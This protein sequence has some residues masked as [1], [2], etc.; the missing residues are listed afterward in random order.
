MVVNESV[1]DL[2]VA[3]GLVRRFGTR[4]AVDGVDLVGRRGEIVGLL[5][6]NG[7]GKTTT[8]RMFA[9]ILPP[10]A[11]TVLLDGHDLATAPPAARTPLAYLPEQVAPYP[12][13]TVASYLRFFARVWRVRRS[14]VAGAVSSA[15]AALDL[16][17][18]AKQ[19]IGTLSHGYQQRVAIAGALVHD[20]QVLLLDEPTTGLDPRQVVE[21]REL[22]EDLARTRLVI[23][24]THRL[25][26]ASMLCHRVLVMNRGHQV[27][28]G[29]PDA[30]DRDGRRHLRMSAA[31][32]I[33]GLRSHLS[34]L[35][36][37]SIL[38]ITD[39]D[40]VVTA[41]LE[42]DV[43]RRA[44]IARSVVGAGWDLLELADEHGDLE[45]VFLQLTR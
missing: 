25:S 11:G 40:G 12:E 20:P 42:S 27:A 22:I 32:P 45:D 26:E 31:A 37:I 14:D 13:M 8:L 33:A 3:D 23:L 2:L 38:S 17:D 7:A 15:L 18:V 1:D 44:S 16:T 34:G 36:G 35:D 9:G 30:L 43:D 41:R 29:P 39:H 10:S 19:V 4:V 5:G 21:F 28:L 24:S 6:P